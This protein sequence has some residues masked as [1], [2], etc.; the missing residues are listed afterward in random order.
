MTHKQDGA[1]PRLT[2]EERQI[3]RDL[4]A[5]PEPDTARMFE[6]ALDAL[7]G[8]AASLESMAADVEALNRRDSTRFGCPCQ[9]RGAR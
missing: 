5:L 7:Q 2:P 8:I 4:G 9:C 1:P 6:D 3:L